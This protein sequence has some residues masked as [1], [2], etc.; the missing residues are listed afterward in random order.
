MKIIMA[1]PQHVEYQDMKEWLGLG[2]DEDWDANYFE[3][4]EVNNE[5]KD[6]K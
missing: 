1:D 3:L 5:F 4:E 6:F 2:E